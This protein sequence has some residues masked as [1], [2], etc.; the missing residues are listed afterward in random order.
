ML[1]SH[2][3]FSM[4]LSEDGMII[5]GL[6]FELEIQVVFGQFSGSDHIHWRIRAMQHVM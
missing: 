5:K 4:V 1:K 3:R 6:D 2:S